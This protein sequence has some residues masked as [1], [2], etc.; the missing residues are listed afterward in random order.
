MS[1]GEIKPE[2]NIRSSCAD[3]ELSGGGVGAEADG[4]KRAPVSM[5][6]PSPRKLTKFR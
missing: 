1:Q 4:E 6:P 2:P 5:F 3:L